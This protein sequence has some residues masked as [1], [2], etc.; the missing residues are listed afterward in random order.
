MKK[1]LLAVAATALVSSA[2]F[3]TVTFDTNSGTGFVG[4]GDVQLAF[5]W[6]N[7]ALQRNAAGV[8]FTYDS[9]DLYSVECE[10]D[11]T[12]GNGGTVHHDITVPR[13]TSVNS[14]IAYDPRKNSNGLNGPITGFFLN[15]FGSSTTE[16]TVPVVGGNCPGNSNIALI[17]SVTL[18]ESSGGG[19]MV[20]YGGNS[21]PL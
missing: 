11:T 5:G 7:Q 10:W 21:V 2:A 20:N 17:T 14:T 19:L 15:G 16:G 8:T 13:H 18:V 9:T 6:N 12:T 3:A 1:L 4:K